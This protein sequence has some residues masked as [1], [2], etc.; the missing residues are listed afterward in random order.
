MESILGPTLNPTHYDD[1]STNPV[2][3]PVEQLPISYPSHG[4][5]LGFFDLM[6]F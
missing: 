4:S 1:L 5:Y 3:N 2:D 6:N